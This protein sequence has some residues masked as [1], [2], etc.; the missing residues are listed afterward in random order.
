[1]VR[2]GVPLFERLFEN[3]RRRLWG[4]AYR[5]TGSAADADDVVQDTF[6]RALTHPPAGGGSDDAAWRP[7]LW[8]IAVNLARDAYR[9]RR[10][11]AYAGPW[12]PAAVE[13]EPGARRSTSRPVSD[14]PD[15]RYDRLESVT[16][17][18]LLALEAL[19]PRQRAVLLLC[20]VF[21][22]SVRET[23]AALDLSESNVK[24]THHRARAAMAA[25]DAARCRPDAAPSRAHRRRARAAGRGDDR[26]DDVARRRGAAR[27]R[28]ALARRRRRRATAPAREPIVGARKV[29]RFYHTLAHMQTVRPAEV[30]VVNGLPAMRAWRRSPPEPDWAP[31]SVFRVDVG[32]DDRIV[33]V[34]SIMARRQAAR[35]PLRRAAAAARLACAASARAPPRCA[36]R[37]R[38]A[39]PR[40]AR[41][42]RAAAPAA[43]R[44]SK[45]KRG[46]RVEER[47]RARAPAP[48]RRRRRRRRRLRPQ[49]HAAG[50][51]GRTSARRRAACAA[52]SHEHVAPRLV[53]APHAPHVAL[54]LAVLDQ[55]GDGALD[56][57]I[58]LAI[59]REAQLG[60]RARSAAAAP[61]RSRGAA[62]APGSST[63]CRR[64]RPRR[65]RSAAASGSTGRPS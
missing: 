7:W 64:R 14:P 17:A 10:A 47:R 22:Y 33:A 46:R 35:H 39:R 18:F 44:P 43:A 36:G 58:A 27:R 51:H 20:D 31:R 55:L 1:M 24:V 11:R 15:A 9:R 4:L 38:R 32:D 60:E 53:D 40:R 52:A 26:R 13:T 8:R 37:P 50:R 48:P 25:Y 62:P 23:A 3:E 63:A 30:R 65:A 42:S 19:T 28:R 54:Q 29:A 49:R 45:A 57:L 56:D 12:L 21:D 59:D 6:A 34:H 16:Y 2:T 5:M 41:R 61:R